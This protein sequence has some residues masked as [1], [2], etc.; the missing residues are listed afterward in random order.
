[1][2]LGKAS[3]LV[4]GDRG[5]VGLAIFAGLGVSPGGT[6]VWGEILRIAAL[7][8]VLIVVWIA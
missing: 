7:V 8:I 1:M 3:C 4:F 5:A 6:A 2:G